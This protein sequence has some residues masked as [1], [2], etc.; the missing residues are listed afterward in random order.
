M[1]LE[2]AG[3]SEANTMNITV[4]NPYIIITEK[5]SSASTPIW[6]FLVSSLVGIIVFIGI[7]YIL[8]KIG[9]FKRTQKEKLEKLK[10]ESVH[11]G[12]N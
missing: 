9:F 8:Y 2:R 10:R 3:N 4:S 11:P 7:S 12:K 1:W 6:I 5:M